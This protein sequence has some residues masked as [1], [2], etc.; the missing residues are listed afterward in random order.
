MIYEINFEENEV[1]M[2]GP[3]NPTEPLAQLIE[4]LE[5]G[6]EFARSGGQT[7]ADAIIMSKGIR[8]WHRRVCST[9]TSASGDNNLP[10][11]ECILKCCADCLGMNA[12]DLK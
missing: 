1:K 10:K 12:P 4:Q 3:Y 6:R 2:M 5:K 11:W 7:I 8:F 9:T